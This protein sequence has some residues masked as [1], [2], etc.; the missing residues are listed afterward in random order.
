MGIFQRIKQVV[1][2]NQ[3]VEKYEAKEKQTQKTLLNLKVGDMLA[4]EEIDY[5]VEGII[6]FNDS[7]WGWMEYLI[8]DAT[9][10]WWLSVEM[11]DELEISLSREVP[12]LSQ[13]TPKKY[14]YDGVTYTLQERSVATVE[15]VEGNLGLVVGKKV[16]YWEYSDADDEHFLS[17]EVWDSDEYELSLGRSIAEYNVTIY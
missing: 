13:D 14:E 17:I 6:R 15:G 11:D 4:I 2:S 7:G 12:C 8:K 10:S 9:K 3:S 16:N 1:R 5:Q